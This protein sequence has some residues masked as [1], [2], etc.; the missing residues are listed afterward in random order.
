M[1]VL[2]I[3][4]YKNGSTGWANASKDTIL[5]MDSVGIEVVPRAIKTGNYTAEVPPRILELEKNSVTNC[6][7]CIQNV[8]PHHLDYNGRFK[9]NIAYCVYENM[10]ANLS[11]WAAKI[12][13]MDELWTPSTYSKHCFE[14]MGV[15]IPIVVVPYAFDMS[16]YKRTERMSHPK[17]DG[18]FVFYTIADMNKRKDFLSLIKA[19]HLAFTPNEPVSLLIKTSK[20]GVSG[21]D[22]AR[23]FINECRQVKEQMKLYPRV[24]D[25]HEELII[26]DNISDSELMDIH[27]TGDCFITTS[28]G[29]GWCIP[30][31]DAMAIGNVA[32]CPY[33]HNYTEA[34]FVDY[35]NGSFESRYDR[36]FG[37]TD[38]F[39][40]LSSSREKWLS[41]NIDD[42]VDSMVTIYKTD[43]KYLENAGE[44]NRVF[45]SNFSYTKIGNKIIEILG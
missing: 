8:L 14:T 45:A 21:Q 42:V 25:Y 38:T 30:M 11:G 26:A 44:R 18:N 20:N 2:Y 6:D 34:D 24:E 31:F 43:S 36:V 1:K 7:V 39:F 23:T 35:H 37:M 13:T 32:I 17:L 9:K 16:K 29:E 40:E 28:H 10:N 5:A 15:T 27:S 19:F 3:A 4:H 12:N 33:I 22:C 41:V